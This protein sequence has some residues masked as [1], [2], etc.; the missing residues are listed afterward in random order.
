M[1]FSA[2]FLLEDFAEGFLFGTAGFAA[3]FK[4]LAV[5]AAGREFASGFASA[6]IAL[7]FEI[8]FVL[9]PAG[10]VSAFETAFLFAVF[11]ESAALDEFA[12]ASSET[13]ALVGFGEGYVEG[14]ALAGFDDLFC[15]FGG[16]VDIGVVRVAVDASELETLD[17][18]A[19]ENISGTN[20]PSSL[21]T[22]K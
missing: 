15:V 22:A 21:P 3:A 10:F 1:C 13:L 16:G 19:A 2:E 6:E 17:S 14:F 11:M 7:V 20:T 9:V 18:G 5:F 12:S 4:L 8:A